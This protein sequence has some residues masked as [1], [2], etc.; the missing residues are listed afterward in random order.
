M[1]RSKGGNGRLSESCTSRA[2]AKRSQSIGD[3]GEGIG[4]V[5]RKGEEGRGRGEIND[6]RRGTIAG[7]SVA[8]RAA[9]AP[10]RRGWKR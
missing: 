1:R 7:G 5:G 6:H 4:Q 3:G 8:V 9:T 10:E 2:T